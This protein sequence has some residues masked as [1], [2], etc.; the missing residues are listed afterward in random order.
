M[1]LQP[2]L[3]TLEEHLPEIKIGKRKFHSPVVAYA[4]DVTV[5]VTRPEDFEVIRLAVQKF[6]RASGAR[7]NTRKSKA[8]AVGTWGTNPTALGIDVSE[9]VGI[10][11]VDLGPTIAQ[12]ADACW[13][14]L[15][16]AARALA[17]SAY[18]RTLGLTQRIH[19]VQQYLLAKLWFTTQILPLKREQAQQLTTICSW[20]I[21]QGAIFRVPT[22]TLQLPKNEGG[23]GLS[24][25]EGRCRTLL[26]SRMTK[27]AE[28]EGTVTAA[29]MTH[30]RVQEAIKNPR[31]SIA[32]QRGVSICGVTYEIWLI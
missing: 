14:R 17:R 11:G 3:R 10:L 16:R 20:Y 4:D 1:C 19:Y 2:F 32:Y 23:W 28:K 7:L 15:I 6:E 21:W 12:S 13:K 24:N 29:L 9:R 27:L 8:L 30:L 26:Y 5:V 22:T 31:M 25:I 18:G